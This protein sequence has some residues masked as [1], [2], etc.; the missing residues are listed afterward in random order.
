MNEEET[1]REYELYT[2]QMEALKVSLELVDAS[3]AE[4]R[5]V[6]S[7]LKEISQRKEKSEVFLPIGAGSFVKG[8]IVDSENVILSIGAGV[9]V[10]KSLKD[11]MAYIEKKTSELEGVKKER[12]RNLEEAVKKLNELSPAVE[13]IIEK[14]QR[15]EKEEK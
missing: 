6:S 14:L 11:A 13:K 5:S 8:K 3:L 12:S 7:A 2:S 4:L 1:L 15:E 9:A 10:K